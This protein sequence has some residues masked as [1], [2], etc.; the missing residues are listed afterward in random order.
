M[1]IPIACGAT[2]WQKRDA[3]TMRMMGYETQAR[4]C[5][6]TFPFSSPYIHL[7]AVTERKKREVEEKF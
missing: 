4:Y 1:Y 6:A 2:R 5:R 7:Y 3:N